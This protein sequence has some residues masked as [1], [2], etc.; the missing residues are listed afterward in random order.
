MY[1][2]LA[3]L[4]GTLLH[5]AVSVQYE[6]RDELSNDEALPVN[7]EDLAAYV[8]GIAP[9]ETGVNIP[10]E[11]TPYMAIAGIILWTSLSA[12]Y[13]QDVTT[14]SQ[15][16]SPMLPLSMTCRELKKSD[17]AGLL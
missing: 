9:N 16:S 3:S 2:D 11:P 7:Y 8:L 15:M 12:P 13:D 1:G 5:Q 17:Q 10:S 14:A 6:I 4:S